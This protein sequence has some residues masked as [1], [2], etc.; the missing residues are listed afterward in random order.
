M[1]RE[2]GDAHLAR[3]GAEQC[4]QFLVQRVERLRAG[5]AAVDLGAEIEGEDGRALVVR[6]EQRAVRSEGQRSDGRQRRALTGVHDRKADD[7][8][9]EARMTKAT[10]DPSFARRSRM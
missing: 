5:R 2:V 4:R 8:D 1:D 10:S 3:T 9:S 7:G 6:G